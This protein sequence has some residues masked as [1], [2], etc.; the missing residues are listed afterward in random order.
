MTRGMFEAIN[1]GL[2]V[3]TFGVILLILAWL[4]EE[5]QNKK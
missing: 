3:L 4:D 5:R 2:A 1:Q